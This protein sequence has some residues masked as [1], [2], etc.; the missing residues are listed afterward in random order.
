MPSEPAIALSEPWKCPTSNTA[1]SA[2]YCAECGEGRL[3]P[4]DLTLR[5]P[6]NQVAKAFTNLDGPI[7]RSFRYPMLRPGM[8]TLA[9]MNG[10]RKPYPL[11]L[12]LFVAANVLFFAM[13]S[14]TGAKIFST[15][16][17]QHLQSDI[18][19]GLAQQL[20]AHR[21]VVR[22]TTISLYAP[23]FDHAVAVNGRSM[24]IL[25]VV[26]FAL[27]PAMLFA[28]SRRP[29][30]AHIV[31]SLHFYSFL[32]LFLCASLTVA[33]VDRMFGGRG[34]DSALFDHILNLPRLPIRIVADYPVHDL[35][36]LVVS[37]RLSVVSF[38]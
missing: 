22:Q 27:L 12:Q 26:P 23:V 33:G 6:L 24:V 4:H 37:C 11:P 17:A 30:V 38:E 9:Y 2:P 10:Q 32:L 34:L 21:M 31:F 19:G 1:T 3:H 35:A 15:P 5:G 8:L 16:L 28:C 25:M 20:E 14:L 18:W 36:Q 7:L 29:F 13:Q